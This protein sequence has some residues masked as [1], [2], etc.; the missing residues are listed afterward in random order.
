LAQEHGNVLQMEC[1]PLTIE[2]DRDK[3]WVI[4]SNLV[5]NACK[6]T[7]AGMVQVE[8]RVR[9]EMLDLSVRDTGVGITRERQATFWHE[10]TQV[11]KRQGR[12]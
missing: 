3:L 9:E 10:F 8:I 5:T 6:F 1:D 12:G 4:L 7:R 2:S 11:E